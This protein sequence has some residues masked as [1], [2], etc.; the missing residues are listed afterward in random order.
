LGSSSIVKSSTSLRPALRRGD[1]LQASRGSTQQP[2]ERNANSL[3]RFYDHG[4]DSRC[5]LR[6]RR[7]RC[8]DHLHGQSR[9]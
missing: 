9:A 7:C 5:R 1:R 4:L 3:S 2:A 8:R 6:R